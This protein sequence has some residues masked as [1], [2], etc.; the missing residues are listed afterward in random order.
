MITTGKWFSKQKKIFLVEKNKQKTSFKERLSKYA[1]RVL[2][3]LKRWKQLILQTKTM[4]YTLSQRFV[5][6]YMLLNQNWINVCANV[7]HVSHI[8]VLNIFYQ[9]QRQYYIVDI[10]HLVILTF[11]SSSSSLNFFFLPKCGFKMS[12]WFLGAEMPYKSLF[13]LKTI[14]MDNFHLFMAHLIWF[15]PNFI[16]IHIREM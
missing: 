6:R 15:F 9:W 11:D 16:K 2:S 4:H 8:G 1:W 13:F 14:F 12:I 5:F 7:M 10:S 3:K